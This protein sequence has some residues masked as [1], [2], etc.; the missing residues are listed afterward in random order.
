M[1]KLYW[2][3][4]NGNVVSV[5]EVPFKSED[6][7]ERY[8]ET[9]NEVLSDIIILKRQVR[10]GGDIPDMVGVDR[11]KN[12]VVIENKNVMVDEDILPQLLRYAVWAETHPDAI[13][14]MWLEA[15]EKPKDLEIDWDQ[16]RIRLVV[17]APSIKSTVPRLAKKI[18]YRVDLIEVKRFSIGKDEFILV[19][20][21]D[22]PETE[23]KR[24]TAG[25]GVYD[26]AYF[27]QWGNPHSLETFFDLQKDLEGIVR[28]EG[29][30]LESRFTS[31]AVVF[32][33]GFFNA[34]G[35]QW[36]TT[37]S[38]GIFANLPKG[39]LAQAKRLCPYPIEY[40]EGWRGMWLSVTD[41]L[42]IKKLVPLLRLAYE[43][44]R[45]SHR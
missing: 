40:E 34:F 15:E 24:P 29:W 30:E 18:D 36:H 39:K 22:E 31:Y 42:Q 38:L 12:I 14:A 43:N 32:K 45:D 16:V 7:F 11:E 20:K 13:K 35:I 10:A 4:K 21:L 28:S 37:K 19:R 3:T 9:A 2:K 1:Q 26:R 44:V 5:P 33:H 25:R 27:E 17:L 8:I 23:S 6:E 41:K